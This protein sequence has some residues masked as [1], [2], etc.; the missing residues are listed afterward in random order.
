M[1]KNIT[2]RKNNTMK[3]AITGPESTGKTTLAEELA[4]Y[5]QT[6]WVE[7]FAR[8]FLMEKAGIYSD[9]DV[10]YIA[11]QQFKAEQTSIEKASGLLICDTEF[12]NLKIWSIV[13]YGF[14]HQYILDLAKHQKYDLILLCQTDIPWEDDPLREHPN[15]R[16]ELFD[17]FVQ[18]LNYYKHTYHIIT[19]STSNIRKENAIF[20]INKLLDKKR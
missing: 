2:N 7:E 10:L 17:M 13:K 20:Q 8:T 4:T 15:M 18:E 19:G 16:N 6:I 14:C 3:V 11:E 1:E 5:Y 9:K 12:I